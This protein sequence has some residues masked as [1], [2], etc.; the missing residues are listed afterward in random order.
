MKD[1]SATKPEEYLEKIRALAVELQGY[2]LPGTGRD[3]S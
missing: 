3:Y 2:G 1:R